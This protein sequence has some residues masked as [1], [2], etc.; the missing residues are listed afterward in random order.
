MLRAFRLVVSYQRRPFLHPQ[1]QISTRGKGNDEHVLKK[2]IFSLSRTLNADPDT[3]RLSIH[4]HKE[5]DAALPAAEA[6]SRIYESLI[7]FLLGKHRVQEAVEAHKRMIIDGFLSS[8]VLD[9]KMIGVALAFSTDDPKPLL[10]RLTSIFEDKEYTQ[11]HFS[12]LVK[13]MA[14]FD[15]DKEVV[16]AVA[17]LF[18]ASRG[19]G[20]SPPPD[21]LATIVASRTRAGFTAQAV[22]ALRHHS[23]TP[24]NRAARQSSHLPYVRILSALRDTQTRDSESVNNVLDIMKAQG[25]SPDIYVLNILLAR[26]VRLRSARNALALYSIMGEKQNILPDS[27]TFGSL[28]MLYRKTRLRSLRHH[29]T[30]D[31]ITAFP[32]RALYKDFMKATERRNNPIVVSTTLMNVILRAF[33]RHRDYAG[34]YVVLRSYSILSV[35]L[36]PRT[37]YCIVK[38]VVRRIWAETLGHR[39][40]GVVCWSDRFLGAKRRDIQLNEDLVQDILLLISHEDFELSKPWYAPGDR[41]PLDV[42]PKYQ[43]PSMEIME[44]VFPEADNVEYPATPLKRIL[45]RALLAELNCEGAPPVSEAIAAARAE[46]IY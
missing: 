14:K 15:V 45:R 12:G 11:R 9:A 39:R 38:H 8:N 36:D 40:A 16:D 26:A 25:L 34:A 31:A 19:P 28:F 22:E 32:P 2:L 13:A 46:M 41:L 10:L 37:Y 30:I 20:Y 5:L 18:A 21:I 17:E 3:G 6:P 4:V 23:Q 1:R 24:Q 33:I 43:V 35:P 27:F 7:I 29:H 44:S 42:K